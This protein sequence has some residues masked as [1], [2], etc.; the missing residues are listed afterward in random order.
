MP[1]VLVAISFVLAGLM[2]VTLGLLGGGGSILTVPIFRYVA[3]F[4]PKEA[5][6]FSLGVVGATSLIGAWGHWRAG[7]ARLGVAAVFGPVSMAGAY[8][9]AR[10]A[11]HVAGSAQLMLF[12]ALMLVAAV[13]MLRGVRRREAE[14]PPE[15]GLSWINGPVI[16]ALGFGVG[17]I[18]GLVGI[19]GG[20]IILPALV[21]LM[22]MPM[23]QAVGTS[24]LVMAMNAAAGVWGYWDQVVIP[25]GYLSVFTAVAIAGI[26]VGTWLIA[27]I[28]PRHL[29]TAFAVFLILM[30]TWILFNNREALLHPTAAGFFRAA[31]AVETAVVPAPHP[32]AL[33][34][35]VR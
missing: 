4:E 32:P 13:S 21:L 33:S 15:R 30:G 3:G 19:G 1:F 10:L 26:L 35:A 18:T 17:V 27:Y 9:G 11:A 14:R 29:R 31:P 24:L 34:E 20:F 7:H 22:R 23:H 16:G 8:L 25:W 12:G 2:G 28:T 6:A 5:I